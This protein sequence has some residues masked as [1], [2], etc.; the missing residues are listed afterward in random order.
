MLDFCCLHCNHLLYLGHLRTGNRKQAETGCRVPAHVYSRP[1]W[2]AGGAT[3]L[4]DSEYLGS[5]VLQQ[6]WLTASPSLLWSDRWWPQPEWDSPTP[7]A[8]A[9][10]TSRTSMM[11][12][13]VDH[14]GYVW[15]KELNVN[16]TTR[17]I[18]S[19]QAHLTKGIMPMC[20]CRVFEGVTVC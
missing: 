3:G 15:L 4:C 12:H 18:Y 2:V 17:D 16:L 7:T 5:A 10:T 8:Q 19:I 13:P 6:L 9:S 20:E 14:R 1:S 11:S